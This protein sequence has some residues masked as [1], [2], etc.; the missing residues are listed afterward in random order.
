MNSFAQLLARS[1]RAKLDDAGA[2]YLDYITEAAR[3]MRV[4]VQDLLL[5]ARVGGED[6]TIERIDANKALA[7]ALGNLRNRIEECSGVVLADDL[8]VVPASGILL[9][10]VLQNLISNA[11]KYCRPGVAP[12]VRVSA[13]RCGSEWRFAVRD[14]GQGISEEDR[15]RIF[16]LFTRLHDRKV[17]GT[18]IGLASVKRIVERHGGRVWVESEPR[19]RQHVLLYAAC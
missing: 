17:S 2:E 14:N 9:A 16:G 1:H 13:E 5:Y 18:G 7:V 12:E 8:P 10:Q 11:L 15:D 19:G 6:L 3:H 4:L